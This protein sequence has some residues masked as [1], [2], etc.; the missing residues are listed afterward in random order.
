MAVQFYAD[1]QA[2]RQQREAAEAAAE[3]ARS[4][5][6]GE[7]VGDIGAQLL[8]GAVGLG[9]AAYGVGNMATLG[10]L[11]RATGMSRN[12]AETNDIINS[13]KS[14]PTQAALARS[15]ASFDEGIGTG[16]K[17]A[18]TDPVLLQ[19]LLVSN[20]P[21]II[22]AGAGA[23]FGV[24]GLE[25]GSELVGKYAARGAAVAGGMQAGG[26]ADVETINAALDAG[27]TEGEAQAAGL[28]AGV[29]TGLMTPVVSKLTGAAGLEGAVA[30]KLMG[31]KNPLQIAGQTVVKAALGGAAKEGADETIQSGAETVIRNAFT[32]KDITAGVAQSAAL[33]GLAGGVLG[34]GL[35]AFSG[36]RNNTPQRTD[37]NAAL[38]EAAQ[39]AGVEST[40]GALSTPDRPVLELT[41]PTAPV[42]APNAPL[43]FESTPGLTLAEQRAQ[44]TLDFGAAPPVRQAGDITFKP[45]EFEPYRPAGVAAP[46]IEMGGPVRQPLIVTPDGDVGTPQQIAATR[47]L[48]NDPLYYTQF[49]QEQQAAAG[50]VAPLAEAGVPPVDSVQPDLLNGFSDLQRQVQELTQPAGAGVQPLNFGEAM[51]Q[52][53]QARA[54]RVQNALAEVQANTVAPASELLPFLE[55]Q[56]Q[57]AGAKQSD[58]L[59]AED[60]V[61]ERMFTTQP[62]GTLTRY[63]PDLQRQEVVTPAQADAEVKAAT[64]WKEFMVKNLGVKPND[65]QGKAWKAFNDAA[66]EAGIIPASNEA[67][68]FLAQQAAGFDPAADL[69]KFALKMHEKYAVAPVAAAEEAA[70][71]AVEPTTT[72]APVTEPEPAPEFAMARQDGQD[73]TVTVNGTTVKFRKNLDAS[74]GTVA[75]WEYED[76]QTGFTTSFAAPTRADAKAHMTQVLEDM[77]KADVGTASG[78]HNVKLFDKGA[79]DSAVSAATA[80]GGK[81]VDNLMAVID[82]T[83]DSLSDVDAL[84]EAYIHVKSTPEYQALGDKQRKMVRESY[85]LAYEELNGKFSRAGTS[86]TALHE[87]LPVGHVDRI[88]QAVTFANNSRTSR[89]APVQL[90]NTVADFLASRPLDINGNDIK[91]PA[92]AK[93]IYL[94]D[95]TVALVAENLKDEKDAASTILHERTHEG[96][97]GLLGDNLGA[98]A[99]RLWANAAMR[100]LMKEKQ[101]QFGLDR[102]T[103]AEEVLTDLQ[104]SKKRLTGDVFSK[105]KSGITKA[106]DVMLGSNEIQVSNADVDALLDDVVRYRTKGI[107][108]PTSR[109]AQ[110]DAMKHI[111]AMMSG[112]P[113]KLATAR[114]SR[115]LDT[116]REITGDEETEP[117]GNPSSVV[118]GA[119]KDV[120]NTVSGVAR[121]AVKGN[122]G[123]LPRQMYRAL[124][125]SALHRSFGHLW[126][127]TAEDGTKTNA[128]DDFVDARTAHADERK[129]L[130]YSVETVSNQLEALRKTNPEKSRKTSALVQFSTFFQ[131]YPDRPADQQPDMPQFD[132]KEREDAR[133]MLAR[134]W[135][136]VGKEGQSIYNDMQKAYKATFTTRYTAIKERIATETGIDLDTASKEELKKFQ[137]EFGNIIDGALHSITTGP[138]SP[139]KRYG[140]FMVDIRTA[141]GKQVEFTGHDTEA[142]ALEFAAQ[143]RARFGS[144][145]KV[146]TLLRS[147][148]KFSLDGINHAFLDR[149]QKGVSLMYPVV[150]VDPTLPVTEQDRLTARNARNKEMQNATHETLVEAYLHMIPQHALMQ[151]ANARKYVAGFPLDASRAFHSHMLAAADNIANIKHNG[152][153]TQALVNMAATVRKKGEGNDDGVK[154]MNVL[155]A[156]KGQYSGSLEEGSNPLAKAATT[157]SFI[158]F[159]LTPSQLMINGLQTPLVAAPRL[160]AKF[161]TGRALKALATA[162]KMFFT[163]DGVLGN[164]DTNPQ[165]AKVLN[166]LHEAGQDDY[167]LTSTMSGIAAGNDSDAHGLFRTV[168]KTLAYPMHKSE[169]FNRQITSHAFATMYVEKAASEGKT[170]TDDELLR[171]TRNFIDNES[172]FNY[173]PQNSPEMMQGPWKRAIWQF[174]NY[175]LQMLALLARDIKSA[176]FGK[177]I[178]GQDAVDPEAAKLARKT[179]A[180]TL[181]T[182]LGLTGAAGTTLSPIVFAIMDA[183]RDDDELLDARTEALQ[184]MSTVVAHGLI[185][186][187][188]LLGFDPTRVEAGA[189]IPFFGDRQYVPKDKTAKDEFA[190]YLQKAA[191]PSVGLASNLWESASAMWDGDFNTAV[192]KGLPKGVADAYAAMVDMDGVRDSK[193]TVVYDPSATDTIKGIL[194]IKSMERAEADAK[195][196]AVY[197]AEAH[198]RKLAQR[199]L[200]KVALGIN[201]EDPAL[202]QEGTER[203]YELMQKHPEMVTPSMLKRTIVGVSKA[204]YNADMYGVG[205]SGRLSEEVLE[206]VGE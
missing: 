204:Q 130:I 62:D 127:D 54:A 174:Q 69:P 166:T 17:N 79:F 203:F 128:Y 171:E 192:R 140:N 199:A 206:A 135:K 108:T 123:T 118:G 24:R 158:Q 80:K 94:S 142:E 71:P 198:V 59:T 164:A 68:A 1:L 21:S 55:G 46:V 191:G 150:D 14:A 3:A 19:D 30:A 189:I 137:H 172:H 10:L 75:T 134:L 7:V 177:L 29:V 15:S 58:F 169:V 41:S 111:D 12:F 146:S 67:A 61:R 27:M 64:S 63:N 104:E 136:Q 165:V 132:A 13:W 182:Q 51:S 44:G 100:K 103:A 157:A 160:A 200:T 16:L 86:T 168:M 129:R 18:I 125:V 119:M 185:G 49:A 99:N 105:I 154:M 110:A 73:H 148:F 35:G 147:E 162:S 163:K 33:G 143:Q 193:G 179:L 43:A 92:D 112:V 113:D 175:R 72:A 124:G 70:P 186:G 34:G 83:F 89:E 106:F 38:A 159:M 120:F 81:K 183:F 77:T 184:G 181:T 56:Q 173:D 50:E 139:L 176:E 5:T 180:Y 107:S 178:T 32:G 39:A 96:L 197:Q 151:A 145:V 66:V 188:P 31:H 144:E 28:G 115:A 23:Q 121:A 97:A 53:K 88:T 131:I 37:I 42:E 161:T 2:L 109:M 126:A 133:L 122:V 11:D 45:A 202:Q 26:A 153:I 101:E 98:V 156:V 65:L 87:V 196:G 57:L 155:N 8:Q 93:G 22:P 74:E 114:F 149:I 82:D 167:T 90:F 91:V 95:G 205:K 152:D 85:E 194:G 84:D 190:Y 60:I 9:Q 20:L 201:L 195:R 4:R 141:D 138:Y 48:L 52:R 6:T 116:L 25:K 36:P 170:V 40:A 117:V 47:D 76:P 78:D 187:L 102:V